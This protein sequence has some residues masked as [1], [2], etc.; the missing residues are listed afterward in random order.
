MIRLIIFD[1]DGTLLDFDPF[2]V[3]VS[4]N[5]LAEL[6]GTLHAPKS[7]Q[8]NLLQALGV[9]DGQTD[10]QGTLAWGTYRQMAE[11]LQK[12]LAEA[13]F[14]CDVERLV[15]LTTEAY[16]HQAHTGLIYPTCENIRSVL[17]SLKAQGLMLAVVTTDDP[18]VT[19]QCLETLDIADLFSDVCTDDGVTPPKPDPAWMER[20]CGQYG[21][22][23]EEILMVGDTM[24]DVRFARNGGV[25][26]IGVGKT[27][28][29]RSFLAQH[30][31]A[32]VP[33]VSHVVLVLEKWEQ[34]R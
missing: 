8:E 11:C 18:T 13:G 24:T 25:R 1:K 7:L 28:G 4:R 21:L 27:E 31:D 23:R 34:A 6:L 14:P 32:A 15:A 12:P 3:T 22:A 33:D 19:A 30:A 9:R 10:I 26:V 2:W 29:N 17:L 20:L 5:A 16:H